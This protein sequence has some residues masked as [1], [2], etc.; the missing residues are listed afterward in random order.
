ML[1]RT[2]I[3]DQCLI[4][5]HTVYVH[6]NSQLVVNPLSVMIYFISKWRN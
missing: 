5:H 6:T 3:A 1:N 4:A 2:Y